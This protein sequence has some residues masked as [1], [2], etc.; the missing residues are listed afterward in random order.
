M[1][2]RGAKRENFIVLKAEPGRGTKGKEKRVDG[3]SY[4][5]HLT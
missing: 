4:V 1:G 2:A 5:L 3:K